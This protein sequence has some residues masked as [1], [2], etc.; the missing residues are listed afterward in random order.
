MGIVT[1]NN[2]LT[3]QGHTRTTGIIRYTGIPIKGNWAFE[4]EVDNC[5]EIV[6]YLKASTADT[7]EVEL[8]PKGLWVAGRRLVN[9]WKKN[10]YR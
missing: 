7:V 5:R 1:V 10:R 6:D 2:A 9:R 8:N 4:I 3:I